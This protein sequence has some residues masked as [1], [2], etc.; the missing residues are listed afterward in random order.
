MAPLNST[1]ANNSAVTGK[2]SVKTTCE[3]SAGC[4][5][6]RRPG[7]AEQLGTSE[8]VGVAVYERCPLCRRVYLCIWFIARIVFSYVLMRYGWKP[9]MY[10]GVFCVAPHP[11]PANFQAEPDNY[12]WWVEMLVKLGNN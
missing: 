6:T 1:E 9:R 7:G 3:Y 2:A 4:V 11:P 5:T 10:V 8:L 12:A